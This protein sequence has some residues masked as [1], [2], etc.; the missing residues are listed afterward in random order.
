MEIAII[1]NG[2]SRNLF[3]PD[4]A[5]YDRV[6]ACNYADVFADDRVFVDAFA[7]RFMRPGQK[8]D[9]YVRNDELMWF[10]E[11]CWNYLGEVSSHPGGRESLAEYFELLGYKKFDYPAPFRKNQRFFN[12]GHAAFY[13]A[14]TFYADKTSSIHLFG[15]DSIFTGD[16]YASHSNVDLRGADAST[17]EQTQESE[18]AKYWYQ[19]WVTL[20]ET[21]KNIEGIHFYGHTKDPH[22][23]FEDSRV[24]I[25]EIRR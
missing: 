23:S 7:A 4:S 17:L 21:F 24:Q 9:H 12:C 15:F 5:L 2:P 22:F 19:N 16:H 11:R 1:G 20:F 6:I 3:N 25:H 18:D 8:Y 10:G 14:S 13:I